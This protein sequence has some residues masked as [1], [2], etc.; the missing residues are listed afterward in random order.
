MKRLNIVL[1]LLISVSFSQQVILKQPTIS[2]SAVNANGENARLSGTV[3]QVFVGMQQS[4]NT[5]LTAG[6][7]G[8]ISSILLEVDDLMP[9][10]FALSNAYPNPFNPTVKIDFEIP[11]QSEIDIKIFDLIGRNVFTHKQ[12]FS[13]SGQYTFQWH[14]VNNSGLLISSGIYLVTIQHK[15]KLYIQKITFLK[16]IVYLLEL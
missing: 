14:G 3:G 10:E 6:L 4:D 12:A 9:M 13:S 7:W 15:T 2:S 1:F 11:G 16:K 8:S 5:I